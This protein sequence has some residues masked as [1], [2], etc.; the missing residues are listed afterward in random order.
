MYKTLTNRDQKSRI[1]R[2]PKKG[3]CFFCKNKTQPDFKEASNL[4]RY[5]SGRGKILGRLETGVCKKHQ[6]LLAREIKKARYL[7]LLPYIP[8]TR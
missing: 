1:L 4:E 7:A 3:G 6:R 2:R 5:I 8:K